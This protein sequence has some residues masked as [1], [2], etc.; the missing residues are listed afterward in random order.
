[1]AES[2]SIVASIEDVRLRSAVKAQLA[3]HMSGLEPKAIDLSAFLS[4]QNVADP[5][6]DSGESSYAIRAGSSS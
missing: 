2:S 6:K 1:M 3:L 5:L 4:T